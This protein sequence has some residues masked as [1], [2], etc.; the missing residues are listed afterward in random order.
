MTGS[1]A[2]GE[3]R[4]TVRVAG[5]R[6]AATG[7]AAGALVVAHTLRVRVPLRRWRVLLGRSSA[8]RPPNHGPAGLPSRR[9]VQV[10]R[11][12]D[13]ADAHLPLATTCLDRAVAAKWLLRVL[14]VRTR[15]VIG[16]DA[17][18]PSRPPHAWLVSDRGT[19]IIGGVDS[20]T[21]YVAATEFR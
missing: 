15:L 2:S 17:D 8:A 18:E 21:R 16:L 13:R 9:A 19:P 5:R 11:A 14:G 10:R 20:E 3:P 6:A 4:Q 7:A 1:L 12:V